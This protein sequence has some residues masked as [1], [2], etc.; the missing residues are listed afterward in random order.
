MLSSGVTITS[1]HRG[2]LTCQR[3]MA[4]FTIFL[5]LL[6]GLLFTSIQA[7]EY[8]VAPFSINDGIFG[9]LFFV[10]TGFHGFHV[11]VGSLFLIVCLYRQVGYQFTVK[12]HI[13]FEAAAW[14]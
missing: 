1:A 3:G 5:T 7:F 10:L 4:I 14:Y 12:Q 9:S 11:F 8:L 2:I 6:L 13:G